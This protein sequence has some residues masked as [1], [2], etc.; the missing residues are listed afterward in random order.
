M[1]PEIKTTPLALHK[2]YLKLIEITNDLASTLDL[3]ILLDR[4]VEAAVDVTN[5]MAA[6]ILLYDEASNELYFQY[7]TSLDSPL[8]KGLVVPVEGSIAGAIVTNREPIIVSNVPDDPRHFGAIGKTT[9]IEIESLLGVP[10]ITQD[11]VVGVLEA[12]NKKIGEFT[13]DDQDLLTT[14]GSQAAVAIVNAR[15]FQQ[16]DLIAEMV[17]ELRTPLASISTASHLLMR[18]EISEMQR[19]NMAETIERETRRLSDMTSSFLDLARLESGRS[20]FKVQQV[21]LINLLEEA[22]EI[23]GGQIEA[24]GLDLEWD[25]PKQLPTF[26]GDQDKI[27]QV[28]LNLLSNAIKYNRSNGSI[29]VNAFSTRKWI[30]FSV[31]DTGRGIKPEHVDS[32]FQKFFRVPGSD[33]VAQGTGLGLS[34]TKKIVESHGGNIEVGSTAGAGTTFIVNLPLDPGS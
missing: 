13:E 31:S 34:I 10:L 8:M 26:Q 7:S 23:M 19:T 4:I 14:L 17:H 20:Q 27:K 24:Q 25:V 5:S 3:D 18:P 32:L 21:D 6:S 33:K 1:S 2:R 11:K 22:R 29:I 16:S 9:E 30:T 15:L 28:I 12:I